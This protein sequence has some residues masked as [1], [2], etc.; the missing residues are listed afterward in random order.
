MLKEKKYEG[1]GSTPRKTLHSHTHPSSNQTTQMTKFKH[2]YH[3]SK[4][5]HSIA[6]NQ[7]GTHEN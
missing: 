6:R 1:K 3:D 7:Q 2:A 5:A 4:E